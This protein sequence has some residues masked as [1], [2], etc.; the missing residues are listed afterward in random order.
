M[1]AM[2]TFGGL[3]HGRGIKGGSVAKWISCMIFPTNLTYIMYWF[4]DRAYITSEQHV[5]ARCS[6]IKRDAVDQE[7]IT[8]YFSERNALEKNDYIMSISTSCKGSSNINCHRAF[9]VGTASMQG[10]V[11][12]NFDQVKLQEKNYCCLSRQ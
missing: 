7:K 4:C 10:M 1:R 9:E 12:K 5:Y 3:T 8:K 6:R 11:G 2:K